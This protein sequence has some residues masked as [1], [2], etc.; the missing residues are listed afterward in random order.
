MGVWQGTWP[1]RYDKYLPIL[2]K[3]RYTVCGS[4]LLYFARFSSV[5]WR[6]KR[7]TG[8]KRQVPCLRLEG[9]KMYCK[10]A[11]SPGGGRSVE[12]VGWR[13]LRSQSPRRCCIASP[14]IKLMRCSSVSRN[15][16]HLSLVKDPPAV[17]LTTA[18]IQCKGFNEASTLF[19]KAYVL[20]A[21][22][23]FEW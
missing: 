5:P 20:A 11:A 10:A 2:L 7:S 4:N 21:P 1:G 15:S 19:E 14:C 13:L 6:I 8:S 18:C 9:P 17:W 23:A 16:T 22:L 3:F 12:C